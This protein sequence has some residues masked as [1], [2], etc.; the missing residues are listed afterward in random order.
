MTRRALTYRPQDLWVFLGAR[1]LAEAAALSQVV[2]IGWTLY[3][4]SRTPLTLG[5]VGLVEFVPMTLLMLPVG[6]LCDRVSP[7][8][9]LGAGLALQ[10]LCAGG[11]VG[12]SWV[13]STGLWGYYGILSLSG[14]SRALTEP[15]GQTLL[16]LLIPTERIARAIALSS[17]VWQIAAIAGPALGG[18]ALAF[19]PTTAYA[20]CGTGFGAASLAVQTISGRFPVPDNVPTLADRISRIAE[21]LQFIRIRPVLLG[22]LSLDM[23]SVLLGGATALLPV[24][25][26]DILHAGPIGLGLLRSGPAAGAVLTALY[27]TRRPPDRRLGL[28]LFAAVALFGIA[29]VVF[30][31]STSLLLSLSAL[32]VVGASDMVSVNIRSSI[33]Q[34]TTPDAFRGRVSAAHMLSVSTSSELGAFESGLLATLIGT[35][36]SV[37]TGGIGVVLVAALWAWWFPALRQV[38]RITPHGRD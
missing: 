22:A 16:P 4:I 34:L 32:V 35:V 21:G 3:G 5:M 38:D 6:E 19:G 30:S 28:K 33:L 15:S 23:V 7:R 12:L 11:F 25:A 8:R 2:A 36:P 13:H 27:L 24:Y 10:M 31:L 14:V 29:T 9:V 1:F 26:R 20:L 18:L 37:A 17:S